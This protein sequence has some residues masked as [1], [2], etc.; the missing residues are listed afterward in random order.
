LKRSWIYWHDG[1]NANVERRILSYD[2]DIGTITTN[3]ATASWADSDKWEI[4]SHSSA[5][6]KNRAINVAIREAYP[7]F[8]DRDE[9][10]IEIPAAVSGVYPV[11]LSVAEEDF[12]AGWYSVAKAWYKPSDES[13][14]TRVVDILPIYSPT[15]TE[16][17][18]PAWLGAR[19]G[20]ILR[21]QVYKPYAELSTDAGTTDVPTQYITY[22]ALETL[23]MA[24]ARTEAGRDASI[25]IQ[26]AQYYREKADQ[27]KV[28]NGFKKPAVTMW[29]YKGSGPG[30]RRQR[31][32]FVE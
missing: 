25:D 14:L 32:P 3:P 26:T 4:N 5:A 28:I 31:N 1:V 18:I 13:S 11:S 17:L 16:I 21:I 22:R 7:V 8:A 29:E 20:A 6:D 9:I 30:A 10:D 27:F 19:T 15:L 23:L 12:A 24:K 2:K